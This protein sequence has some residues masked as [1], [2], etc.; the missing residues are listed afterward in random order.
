MTIH[1]F[2]QQHFISYLHTK[3]K[4]QQK[5]VANLQFT[6]VIE[7]Y[8]LELSLPLYMKNQ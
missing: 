1:F 2:F 7:N 6:K 3:E 8:N 4:L 5:K